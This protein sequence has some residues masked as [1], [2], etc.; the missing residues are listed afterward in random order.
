MY[1][2]LLEVGGQGIS[3]R[4]LGGDNMMLNLYA[5]GP[6]SDFAYPPRPANAKLPWNPEW[7]ARVRFRANAMTI[8]G[9]PDMG[10]FDTSDGDDRL[11]RSQPSTSGKPRCPGGLKGIAM[12]AAGTCS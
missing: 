7:I 11:Q 9:M 3:V 6:Q 2:R 12:R 4:K 5:Y 1:D 8:L 10:G